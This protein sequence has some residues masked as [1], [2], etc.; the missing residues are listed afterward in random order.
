VIRYSLLVA[1]VVFAV[2]GV[3]AWQSMSADEKQIRI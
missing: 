3:D 1:V 2:I